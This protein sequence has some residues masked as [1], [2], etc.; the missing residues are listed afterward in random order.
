MAGLVWRLVGKLA[1]IF[2]WMPIS[3]EGVSYIVSTCKQFEAIPTPMLDDTHIVITKDIACRS[4][5]KPPSLCC[6][7]LCVEG[8]STYEP[9]REG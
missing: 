5:S 7:C 1:A 2:A 6:D 3:T 8:V 9:T 4:V